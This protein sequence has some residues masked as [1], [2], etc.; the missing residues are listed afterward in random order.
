[1]LTSLK[2]KIHILI[3]KN[4]KLEEQ[5]EYFDNLRSEKKQI[6]NK[7]HH[8][9]GKYEKEIKDISKSI[10]NKNGIIQSTISEK[11]KR[12]EELYHSLLN[13]YKNLD[14]DIG[15]IK[16]KLVDLKATES[17]K[18]SEIQDKFS[19]NELSVNDKL[20]VNGVAY[21]N[22]I[23][24]N[25]VDLGSIQISNNNLKFSNF[26]SKI[27]IGNEVITLKE[28]VNIVFSFKNLQ[29]KCGEN[30]E[31]CRPVDE[32]YFEEQRNKEEEILIN[33]K[34]LRKTTHFLIDKRNN[35]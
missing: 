7:M 14:S 17:K 22:K 1:M 15:A 8:F 26:N 20:D 4:K 31:K 24:T 35:Y 9:A 3:S 21:I 16:S 2:S 13:S 11:S 27:M 12:I 19:L 32:K 30:L 25:L 29:Q 23:N 33:L 10:S 34:N 28:L 5:V 18:F 6:I